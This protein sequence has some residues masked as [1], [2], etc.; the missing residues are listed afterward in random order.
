MPSRL[1][2]VSPY[3][4]INSCINK[5]KLHKQ[6]I[7][8]TVSAW[9][10]TRRHFKESFRNKNSEI[11]PKLLLSYRFGAHNIIN[12]TLIQLKQ[13]HFLVQM[14][15]FYHM[16]NIP[17][18]HLINQKYNRPRLDERKLS[19]LDHAIFQLLVIRF[20]TYLIII[21]FQRNKTMHG[22]KQ[23]IYTPLKF[24]LKVKYKRRYELVK[25]D[26]ASWCSLENKSQ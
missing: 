20:P 3:V 8:V 22:L 18:G 7:K 21:K 23:A 17:N 11:L 1:C 24:R 13:G 4:N 6:V 9:T 10:I 19:F 5:L 16:L 2:E 26:C 12:S 25:V 14:I 15:I